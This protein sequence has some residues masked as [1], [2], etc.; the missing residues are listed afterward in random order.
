[1]YS[2][3]LDEYYNLPVVT[4]EKAGDWKGPAYAYR[5]REDYEDD[6]P[7]GEKLQLLLTQKGADQLTALII[8]A[9]GGSC[10]GGDS[11]EIVASVAATAPRLP[12][13]K[14]IFFGEM[15]YEECELSWINQSDVSPLLRAYPN[16]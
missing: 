13:L 1:M 14:A 16:L 2:E 6:V 7:I 5:L 15:T 9:W 8:G 4:F 10:E 3:L 11:S 12:S